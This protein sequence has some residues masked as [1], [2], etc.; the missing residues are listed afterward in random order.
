LA[1]LAPNRFRSD[2]GKFVAPVRLVESTVRNAESLQPVEALKKLSFAGDGAD[3]DMRVGQFRWKKRLGNLDGGVTRLDDLL[4]N[5]EISPH[6][7]INV[8]RVVLC[9]LHGWL[10]YWQPFF[11]FTLR[12]LRD[13]GPFGVCSGKTRKTVCPYLLLLPLFSRTRHRGSVSSST[14]QAPSLVE[15]NRWK[16][17]ARR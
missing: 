10:L 2:G 13:K 11:N 15:G 1:V 6:E 3:D 7:E 5:R 9:E 16:N 14:R 8:R 12:F 4:R 17:C